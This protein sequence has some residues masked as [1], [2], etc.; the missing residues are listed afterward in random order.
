FNDVMGLTLSAEDIESL[1][2]R[3][4]GWI[5]GLHLAALSM[6]GNNDIPGFIKSF[7]GSHHFV[8]DYLIEEVLLKQSEN[9]K[10]FLLYTSILDRLC[11]PLCDAVLLN[12]SISGQAI[13]E[14]IEQANLFIVPLDHEQQWYRYHHLFADLLLQR[15][16]QSDTL[17][18]GSNDL[19]VAELHIRAS[20]WYEN[21]GLEMK[22]IHHA[23]EA[24]DFERAANL[25]EVACTRLDE[26]YHTENWLD[27]VKALPEDFIH[28]RPVLCVEFAWGLL[29]EGDLEKAE[30][31]L[32]VAERW[33]NTSPEK[34]EASDVRSAGMVVVADENYFQCQ[35][36]SIACARA[37]SAF[38]IGDL[39]ATLE[40]AQQALSLVPKGGHFVHGAINGILTMVYCTNGNLEAT[41]NFAND[42]RD[43]MKMAGRIN[44]AASITPLLSDIRNVQGRLRSAM[45]LYEPSLQYSSDTDEPLPQLMAELYLGLSVINREQGD[46]ETAAQNLQKSKE[47]AKKSAIAD[48]HYRWNFSMA[49][50]NQ[51]MG[52][53]DGALELLHEAMNLSS[54][55]F[56]PYFRPIDALTTRVLVCQGKMSDALNW[57]EER[58]LSV[59]DELAFM[60]EFEHITLARILIAEYKDSRSD[61]SIDEATELLERLVTE[62]EKGGRMGSVIELIVLQALAYEARTDMQLALSHLERAL[63][64]AEPEGYVRIFLDEGLPMVRLL[65]KVAG[66]G[67]S[68]A[69]AAKL[70]T[71]FNNTEGLNE[72]LPVQPA[73]LSQPLIEPLSKREIEVLLLIAQGLSNREIG[74]RLFLA[75]DTVKGHNR[76]IF[77][78]LQVKRRTEAVALAN[79][80]GLL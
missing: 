38:F 39:S 24:R 6:Q 18:T 43:S 35:P 27:W 78:K 77:G 40:Y 72:K 34:S 66:H 65:S 7:S 41:Y 51:S 10:T 9:I 13:L 8:M 22:A 46:L 60:Q 45:S 49:R 26:N 63:S 21:N 25:I 23:F 79:D 68:S 11:G 42:S 59:T 28:R 1:E 36:A 73:T 61:R 37:M 2:T 12:P 76:N 20:K 5:A 3:T 47:M 70:L 58:G 57:V 75:L 69:Y 50:L 71:V 15:L 48:W 67:K 30:S 52:D 53:L 4:E 17:S 55:P 80:L 31:L 62:A 14:Y 33:L 64:L 54:H 56:V 44:F 19:S 74:E 16:H 32:Q 29:T